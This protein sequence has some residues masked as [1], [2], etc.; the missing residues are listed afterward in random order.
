M[1]SL[2]IVITKKE[3]YL[4]VK[5]LLLVLM[6]MTLIYTTAA[7]SVPDLVDAKSRSGYKS[8]R[9]SVTEQPNNNVNRADQTPNQNPGVSP[10][11]PARTA[12]AAN[13]GGFFG[14]GFGRALLLGGVAGLLFG[15]LLGNLGVLGSLLG[16]LVNILAIVVLFMVIRS[17]FT[18]FK[19]RRKQN[20]GRFNE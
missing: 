17:I 3:L 4:P 13:K 9:K 7:I 2:R 20:E 12:P 18:Y 16:F 11:T 10:T 14:G 1:K 6:A 8:P 15:G 19:N 5:K